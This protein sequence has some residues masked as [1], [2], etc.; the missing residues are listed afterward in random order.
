MRLLK[1]PGPLSPARH[2]IAWGEAGPSC[3]LTI[4][5]GEDLMEC[6]ITALARAGIESAGLQLLGGVVARLSFMTGRAVEPGGGIAQ[7]ATRSGPH[8]IACP[9]TVIGGNAILGRDGEGV[10]TLH[11]HATFVDASGAV[12]GGH[13]LPGRCIAGPGGLRLQVTAVEGA[14]FEVGADRE[15]GF[16][17]FQPMAGS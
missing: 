2:A 6:L 4:G 5:A 13:L 11:V 14:G 8:E 16:D 7:V 9:A 3:R 17:I 10:P 12:R 1:Q 15:T